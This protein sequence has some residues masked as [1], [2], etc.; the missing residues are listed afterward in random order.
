[1][2]MEVQKFILRVSLGTEAPKKISKAK[3]KDGSVIKLT[4]AQ[5]VHPKSVFQ[6]TRDL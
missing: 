5:S 3:D 4:G 1:M 2:Q 6:Y